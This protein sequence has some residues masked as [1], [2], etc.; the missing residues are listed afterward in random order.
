MSTGYAS[1]YKARCSA[2]IGWFST[3]VIKILAV[4]VNCPLGGPQ[5]Y[6]S[7]VVVILDRAFFWTF[8][9]TV[10]VDVV[11]VKCYVNRLFDPAC[12]AIRITINKLCFIPKL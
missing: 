7:P 3:A 11:R 10:P 8:Y 4:W 9:S 5:S 12:V 2:V 1:P 6:G